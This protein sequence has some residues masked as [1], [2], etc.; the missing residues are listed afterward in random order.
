M[1]SPTVELA[2][3]EPGRNADDKKTADV[4]FRITDLGKSRSSEL[5]TIP[6]LAIGSVD[7]DIVRAKAELRNQLNKL[8]EQLTDEIKEDSE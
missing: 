1:G 2:H 5:V 4:M 8:V 3:Y 7:R 6:V